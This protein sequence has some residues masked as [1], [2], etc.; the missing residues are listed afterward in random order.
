VILASGGSERFGRDKML[1]RL[2]LKSLV[3]YGIDELLQIFPRVIVVTKRQ[4]FA[5]LDGIYR[6]KIVLA[7]GGESRYRS[8]LAA[9]E[10]VKS[11]YLLIHDGARPLIKAGTAQKILDAAENRSGVFLTG[12]SRDSLFGRSGG[13]TTYLGK[14][15]VFSL[16]TPELIRTEI[17]RRSAAKKT[18][19]A[20]ELQMLLDLGYEDYALVENEMP[21][22]KVTYPEDLETAQRMLFSKNILVGSSFDLH[23]LVKNRPLILGG[24]AIASPV[25]LDG[26]SDADV[27]L[28]A[29]AEA[30]IGAFGAG[31]LGTNYGIRRD[32]YRNASSVVFVDDV[33]K[34]FIRDKYCIINMDIELLLQKPR[35]SGHYPSIRANLARLLNLDESRVNLKA[36][37]MEKIG[38]IGQ[39]EAIGCFVTALIGEK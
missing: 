10:F 31:D 27:I 2:G 14:D 15:S 6:D 38:V 39:N 24:I 22:L 13:K 26:H 18:E 1:T 16:E 9:L 4:S 17:V 12:R 19:Y 23:P 11:D 33:L 5:Y 35:I 25:G 20:N 37:T 32:E 7:E 21:N 36:T 28:H 8:L 34:R 30:I 29:V 3:Q